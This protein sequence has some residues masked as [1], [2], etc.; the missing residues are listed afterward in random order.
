MP[1]EARKIVGVDGITKED[2]FDF[3]VNK[4]NLVKYDFL[5][6]NDISDSIILA[7]AYYK[8]QKEGIVIGASKKKRK[9][10]RRKK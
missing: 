3:V 1:S 7:L 2:G 6:H 5:T 10:K 8:A 4:Y 9:K